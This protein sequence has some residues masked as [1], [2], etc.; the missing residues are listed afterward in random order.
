MNYSKNY[1][2]NTLSKKD[3]VKQ[4]KQLDKS[5]SDYKKGKFTQRDKLKSF[6]SK[7]SG[8]VNQVKSILKLP[9]NLNKI[10]DKL[11]RTDKRQKE[12]KKGL[13]EVLE[14]GKAAYYSSG[15]RPNQNPF[16]W[17]KSRV[18]SVLV[19]GPSRKIDKDIVKKYK[20]PNIKKK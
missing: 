5:V 7:S 14:K 13:E 6:K 15:S 11:T 20:I 8:Y 4:K 3:K 19:G 18:A 9:L 17:G 16:S 12:L 1:I 2:P 10:A